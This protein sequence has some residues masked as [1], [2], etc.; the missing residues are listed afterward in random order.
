MKLSKKTE[1]G[2]MALIDMAIQQDR[3]NATRLTT[4]DIALRQQIPERFLEQQ[5]TALRNAGLISSQRGASG[6]CSLAR[7]ADQI[8]VLD[9]T[10]ALEGTLFDLPDDDSDGRGGRA[11]PGAVREL[12]DQARARLADLFA[13]MSI[14]DLAR[15]ELE[16][17]ESDA[18][19][20][21]V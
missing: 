20:F 10:E 15:R 4:H 3:D 19:M 18:Q 5:M 2:L 16:L 17:R 11:K 13:S 21:Y 8:T 1:Y 9:V 14:A 6:G 7:R 12:V